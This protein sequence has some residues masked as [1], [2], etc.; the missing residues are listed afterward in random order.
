MFF[1]RTNC[2]IVLVGN[3][4]QHNRS[5]QGQALL[6]TL[7]TWLD[8]P[9]PGTSFLS[10]GDQS[11]RLEEVEDARTE[12]MNEW[13]MWILTLISRTGM[14]SIFLRTSHRSAIL[15]SFCVLP[16]KLYYPW[17]AWV[18]YSISQIPVE[19]KRT[20]RHC[21][22]WALTGWLP[23]LQYLHWLSHSRHSSSEPE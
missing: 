7:M 23:H 19:R 1:C 18:R 14:W 22:L 13:L 15:S 6:H 17:T 10:E 4:V 12:T 9:L 20:R 21:N 2:R 5:M 8:P 3:A 11:E 16:T